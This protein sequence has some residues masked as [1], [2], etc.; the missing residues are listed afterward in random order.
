MAAFNKF[1]QFVEDMAKGVH[2]LST[3]T[4]AIALTAAANAPIAANSVLADL[5]QI[6]YTNCSSRVLTVTS[7][8]QVAGVLSLILADLTLTASGGS[9][10]PFRYV[11]LYNDTPAGDPLIGFWDIGFDVTLADTDAYD[12]D[13]D[14]VNGALQ[15]S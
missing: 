6:S 14:G 10:G 4:L 2:N 9:V 5:T 15:V 7:A 1:D 13:F 11:V 12:L 8:E 3:G